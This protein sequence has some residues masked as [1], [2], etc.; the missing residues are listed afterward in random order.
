MLGL[1]SAQVSQGKGYGDSPP[2]FKINLKTPK[3][4]SLNQALVDF[5][6]IGWE[7]DSETEA[8]ASSS[9]TGKNGIKKTLP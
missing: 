8:S 6:M 5:R 4:H 3:R 7:Q 9:S 1:G 2:P